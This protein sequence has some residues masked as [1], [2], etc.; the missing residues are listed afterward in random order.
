M[1]QDSYLAGM[2]EWN[3]ARQLLWYVVYDKETKRSSSHRAPSWSWACLD[4]ELNCKF[5][6]DGGLLKPLQIEIREAHATTSL[7]FPDNDA[8]MLEGKLIPA[9]T[10]YGEKGGYEISIRTGSLPQRARI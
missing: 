8:V 1:T 6:R 3:L 5:V 2:W 7:G 10:L 4:G 9:K